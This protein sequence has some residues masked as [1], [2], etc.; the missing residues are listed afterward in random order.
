MLSRTFVPSIL[1]IT[2][3]N[4]EIIVNRKNYSASLNVDNTNLNKII[5]FNF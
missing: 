3:N 1:R 2:K 5:S 4:D